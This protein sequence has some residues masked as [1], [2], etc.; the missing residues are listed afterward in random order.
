MTGDN[1]TRNKLSANNIAFKSTVTTNSIVHDAVLGEAASSENAIIIIEKVARLAQRCAAGAPPDGELKALYGSE[2]ARFR[3]ENSGIPRS[4][5]SNQNAWLDLQAHVEERVRLTAEASRRAKRNIPAVLTSAFFMLFV[6]PVYLDEANTSSLPD[7]ADSLLG[8]GGPFA[9]TNAD[10]EPG[11]ASGDARVTFR[12][13]C[14]EG[15]N[16]VPPE[17]RCPTDSS[18]DQPEET[19]DGYSSFDPRTAFST[20]PAQY[21]TS[22]A[23]ITVSR[24][25]AAFQIPPGTAPRE[26][27]WEI[28]MEATASPTLSSISGSSG[29]RLGVAPSTPANSTGE[30]RHETSTKLTDERPPSRANLTPLPRAR[31][32]IM[33]H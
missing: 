16:V 17:K 27:D 29:D 23:R 22:W 7:S 6:G 8:A 15:W 13:A 4:V 30:Q 21:L 18:W 2:S 5:P 19:F 9:P 14:E 12:L 20:L 31:P 24:D 1:P 25:G 28:N 32:K 26:A 11:A 3:H 10:G 33:D